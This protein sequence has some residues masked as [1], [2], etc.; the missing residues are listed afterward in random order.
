MIIS[1]NMNTGWIVHPVSFI[2]RY[3]MT[4]GAAARGKSHRCWRQ[5]GNTGTLS[6]GRGSGSSLDE[7][8]ST[9]FSFISR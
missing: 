9:P 3:R 5:T 2:K 4:T 8:K 6:L 1:V 7:G